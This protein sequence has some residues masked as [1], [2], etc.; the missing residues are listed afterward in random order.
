MIHL[1]RF[2]AHIVRLHPKG[3]METSDSLTFCRDG[4]WNPRI[5]RCSSSL[6]V[7]VS[8]KSRQ[9]RLKPPAPPQKWIHPCTRCKILT[10]K[11]TS[12]FG[13]THVNIHDLSPSPPPPPLWP[14][15]HSLPGRLS[16]IP[17]PLPFLLSFPGS[18]WSTKWGLE[19]TE[20]HVIMTYNDIK[21][22]FYQ[23]ALADRTRRRKGG[24]VRNFNS[25]AAL[26]TCLQCFGTGTTPSFSVTTW[27][28]EGRL[29]FFNF[30]LPSSPCTVYFFFEQIPAS[31]IHL[32]PVFPPLP[33]RPLIH[34]LG[35]FPLSHQTAPPSNNPA[36]RTLIRNGW[37]ALL[38]WKLIITLKKLISNLTITPKLTLF[39]S[40]CSYRSHI[41]N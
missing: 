11:R 33:P 29:C 7:C 41:V 6:S 15:S 3:P 18:F 37:T 26:I 8:G 25:Y 31:M 20:W 38:I 27:Q 39:R 10:L 35:A 21:R 22:A 34:P 23:P 2:L 32:L 5:F 24:K 4:A 14:P 19:V 30:H 40:L 1:R 16:P 36:K 9:V 13:L 28:G 12:I 17:V